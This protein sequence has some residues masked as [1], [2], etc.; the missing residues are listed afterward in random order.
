MLKLNKSKCIRD[1][2]E[3]SKQVVVRIDDHT[4]K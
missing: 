2:S 4:K 3:F 1:N